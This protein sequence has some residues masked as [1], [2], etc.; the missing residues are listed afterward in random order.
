MEKYEP[1]TMGRSPPLLNM[2]KQ[3]KKN[4]EKEQCQKE[5]LTPRK[6]IL[7]RQIIKEKDKGLNAHFPQLI[8]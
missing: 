7:L 2:G 1:T 5:T 3:R 8:K 6:D 4:G